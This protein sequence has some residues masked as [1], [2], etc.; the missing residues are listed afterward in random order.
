MGALLVI[1]DV[2]TDVVATPSGPLTP[3]TDT[4]ARIVMRPG[5]SGAN[6]AAWAG[7]RGADTA[8]L[9]RVG[10][11]S[12]DWH[13]TALRAEGVRCHFRVDPTVSTAVVMALIEPDGE[14]TMVTDRGAG[15]LLSETDWDDALLDGVARLHVSG[16]LLFSP[17]GRQ[18]YDTAM[19]AAHR[20]E[21]PV[22]VDPA[23]TG[24]IEQFGVQAFRDAIAPVD[25]LL[26]NLDEARLLTGET[27]PAAA[28]TTLSARHGMA[29]VTCGAAGAVLAVA[30]AVT[31]HVAARQVDVTDSV[32]AGDAFTGAFL[33][34]LLAGDDP[35][36]ALEHGCVTAAE[37]VQRIGGRP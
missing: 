2:V 19:R 3:G 18:L 25:L 17:A 32:G 9:A 29:A 30:G 13:A 1:G 31:A 28:A 11:D 35:A 10:A 34:G 5:G 37:A 24:Y 33:A 12:A 7:H 6:T 21:V 23:S 15:A 26:P 8:L 22:S 36:A 16:Y 27:D 20:R 4:T 14:R